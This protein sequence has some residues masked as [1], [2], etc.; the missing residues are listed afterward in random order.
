METVVQVLI[1]AAL[2][3]SVR[4]EGA[5]WTYGSGSHGPAHW[6]DL[7]GYV[8]CGRSH[9]SPIDIKTEDV[10]EDKDLDNIAFSGYD[11]TNGRWTLKNNG[12]SVQVEIGPGNYSISS[13]AFSKPYKLVQFH[14]HWGNS[15]SKGSEHFIDG[16]QYP[17][18]VQSEDNTNLKP[19][20]DLL[21]NITE[22]VVP[23]SN[24]LPSNKTYYRYHGSLTTPA[25]YESILWSVFPETV[26]ISESQLDQLRK[27]PYF[28]GTPKERMVDNFRP[29]QV[30]NGRVVSKM[31]VSVNDGQSIYSVTSYVLLLSLAGRTLLLG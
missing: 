23:L 10:K 26:G 29:P 18:E 1:F 15:S 17:L 3:C 6:K 5:E 12:H 31:V 24:L 13:K 14:M 30:L 9:Q 28:E 21:P 11:Q 25:C 2:L 16:D 20:L 27:N 7:P 8:A 4:G 22:S 19:I